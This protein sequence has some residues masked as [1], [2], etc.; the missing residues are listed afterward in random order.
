MDKWRWEE[1]LYL[2]KSKGFITAGCLAG[3]Q[4]LDGKQ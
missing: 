4:L 3:D 1:I 2:S